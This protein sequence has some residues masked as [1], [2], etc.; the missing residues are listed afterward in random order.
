LSFNQIV[1]FNAAIYMVD[2]DV[3]SR[4]ETLQGREIVVDELNPGGGIPVES[5]K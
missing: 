2:F 1:N 5:R 4:A 3:Q